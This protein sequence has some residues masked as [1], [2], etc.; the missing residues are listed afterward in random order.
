MTSY[1]VN[2]LNNIQLSVT[3]TNKISIFTIYFPSFMMD[4]A[5]LS[6]PTGI[7]TSMIKFTKNNALIQPTIQYNP[8][9]LMYYIS[10][11]LNDAASLNANYII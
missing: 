3:P 5:I 7:P 9:T 8:T 6:N 10:L 4:Q 11:N 2:T 1:K